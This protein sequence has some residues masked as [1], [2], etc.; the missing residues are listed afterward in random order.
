M[1]TSLPIKRILLLVFLLVVLI[2]AGCS[3][4]KKDAATKPQ[5][6]AETTAIK[7]QTKEPIKQTLVKGK[8]G[9][10]KASVATTAEPKQTKTLTRELKNSTFTKLPGYWS[11]S[12]QSI[13][14][15]GKR[16]SLNNLAGKQQNQIAAS[17][18]K[19]FIA[20]ACMDAANTKAMNLDKQ[21]S[22]QQAEQVGGSGILMD[23]KPGTRFTIRQL[24]E[25]MLTESDNTA[26]NI[27]ID[28]LG[29]TNGTDGFTV[30]DKYLNTWGYRNTQIQR[31]LMDLSNWN[32]GKSNRIS[33][34]D[35]CDVLVK[36]YQQ[37]IPN[38]TTAQRD[39]LLSLMLRTTNRTKLP[40]KLPADVICYNKSGESTYK[41]VEND[42]AIIQR[43]SQV[44]AVVGLSQYYDPNQP[45]SHQLLDQEY[46]AYPDK[47]QQQ[48]NAFGELGKQL[49]NYYFAED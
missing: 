15:S 44:F 46:Y 41:G 47:T 28:E 11:V 13:V 4:A 25:L 34:D 48:I 35:A 42:L 45:A 14:P 20:L 8:A 32:N 22:L 7:K 3:Q 26:T 31:K 23:E 24:I 9:K 12:T 30:L 37:K 18:I 33:A 29:I 27:L 16:V 6:Q 2:V 40:S 39:W 36:L 38:V 19:I 21:H 17:T 10:N 49:A 43:G 1:Q 5:A